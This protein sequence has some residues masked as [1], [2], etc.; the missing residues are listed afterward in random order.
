MKC[1]FET[2]NQQYFIYDACIWYRYLTY[3][4]LYV[5]TLQWRHNGRDGIPNHQPH[6]C[7]LNHLFRRRS[8][9][10]SKIRVTGLCAVNS[11]VTGEIPAHMACNTENVSIDDVIM[12][13]GEK[14]V[15]C[16]VIT[17]RNI[18]V[19]EICNDLV[20][21]HPIQIQCRCLSFTNIHFLNGICKFLVHQFKYLFEWSHYF[22]FP[23]SAILQCCSRL[24]NA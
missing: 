5:H 4:S 23:W 1:Q 6:H 16:N 18:F 2:M 11:P 19:D 17:K 8:K 22:A 9:K 3:K 14:N 12:I 10:T 20:P 13:F 7:L 24:Q 21:K 15:L